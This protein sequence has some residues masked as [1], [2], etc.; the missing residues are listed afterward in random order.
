MKAA[1]SDGIYGMFVLLSFVLCWASWAAHCP[2][3]YS[4][5]FFF[6]KQNQ[7]IILTKIVRY[8]ET[9]LL[10]WA[11]SVCMKGGKN[12][13][14]CVMAPRTLTGLTAPAWLSPGPPSL[15][16]GL[17]TPYQPPR[18]ISPCASNATGRLVSSCSQPCPATGTDKPGT[19]LD[20]CSQL[21][22]SL[23]LAL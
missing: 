16:L 14:I 12:R 11:V 23:S 1:F 22:P 4:E 7:K 3:G 18:A 20:S 19:P 17:R 5:G 9:F 21:V 8:A 10:F 13:R 6:F 2:Y 15:C